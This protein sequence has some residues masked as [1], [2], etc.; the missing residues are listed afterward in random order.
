MI[1]SLIDTDILSEFMRGNP[2]VSGKV[3]EYLSTFEVINIR[4]ITYYEI[5]NGLLYKDARKQ[6][7]KFEELFH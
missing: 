5:M 7:I 3:E 2:N 6:L 4:V 1:E